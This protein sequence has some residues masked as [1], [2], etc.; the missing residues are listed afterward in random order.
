MFFRK[1]RKKNKRYQLFADEALFDS[2]NVSDLNESKFEGILEKSIQDK[3]MSYLLKI[4]LFISFILIAQIFYLQVIN[5]NKYSVKSRNNFIKEEPIFLERGLIYDRNGV[6]LAWNSSEIVRDEFSRRK[7][8]EKDGFSHL[9]GFISYPQKDKKGIYYNHEYSGKDGLEKYFNKDLNGKLGKKIV[10][11]DAFGKVISQN[12]A[13]KPEEAKEVYTSVDSRIQ[14]KLFSYLEDFIEE[15]DF[16]SGAAIIMD[17]KTGRILSAV[18]YP[19]YSSQ[20]L[21]DGEDNVKI[22]SYREDKREPFL[23]RFSFASFVPGSVMKVFLAMAALERKSI[24]PLEKIKTDGK[25]VV[26][27]PY[28]PDRPTIFRDWKNHGFVDMKKAIANSSN[29]YFYIVGGG[30]KNRIGLGIDVIEKYY[31]K[32]GFGS[33]VG[34]KEFSEKFGVVPNIE[35]KE[36]IFGENWSLG[37]TYLTSIGQYGTLVTPLQVV[38]GV[39]SIANGGKL[40]TPTF[41]KFNNRNVIT[42]RDLN[43][44]DDNYKIIREAMRETTL[45]GTAKRLNFDFVK[46]ASK[47]G[48]AQVGAN[49]E[50]VNSWISGFFPYEDPKYSFVVVASSGPPSNTLAVSVVMQ[51]LLNWM[52]KNGIKEYF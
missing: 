25:L 9:L 27:N 23:N 42:K 17:I 19:E 51:N 49:K 8:I 30:Y 15:K 37:D 7:Y 4:F 1:R 35:W 18:S 26:E 10:E 45:T 14:G 16:E 52:N 31:R 11:R 12:I 28:D 32:F 50:K 47:S 40:I 38:V 24:D 44:K 33:K 41:S 29:V 21:S 22:D 2:K 39:A 6:E 46:V 36:R 20:V 43:L 34:I 13:V 48:T 3:N 5:H